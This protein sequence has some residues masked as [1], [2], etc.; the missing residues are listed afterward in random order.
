MKFESAAKIVT[1]LQQDLKDNGSTFYGNEFVGLEIEPTFSRPIDNIGSDDGLETPLNW[2][3]ATPEHLQLI[4]T[5]EI[6]QL[7]DDWVAFL[8]VIEDNPPRFLKWFLEWS[9]YYGYN[10]GG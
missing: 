4:P 7:L 8:K 5:E 9:K 6:F 3:I 10:Q 1:K 2:N